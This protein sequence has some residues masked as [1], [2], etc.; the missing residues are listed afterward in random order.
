[1]GNLKVHF[2]QHFQVEATPSCLLS[3]RQ[4][5]SRCSLCTVP[6]DEPSLPLDSKPVLVT[7]TPNLGIPQNL[8]SGT[9]LKDLTSGPLANDLQPRTSPESENGSILSG[10]GPNHNSPR[11]S[12]FQ[13]RGTHKPGSETLKLQQL[14]ENFDKATTNPNKYLI[15]H[16]V[17][18]CQSSLK[19]YYHTNSGE[20]LFPGRPVMEPSPPKAT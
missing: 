3:S 19:I 18:N 5:G 6:A 1:M 11:V 12:G 14:V 15:C 8:S 7:A 2:C 4:N 17:L 10:V 20:R 9:N 16:C 13:G